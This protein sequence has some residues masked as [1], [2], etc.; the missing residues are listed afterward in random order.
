MKSQN[1][2]LLFDGDCKFCNFWVQFIQ[3]KKTKN[4]FIFLP[5]QSEKGRELLL[6]FHIDSTVDSVVYIWKDKAH[7]KSNAA[8]QIIKQFGY[9]WHTLLLFWLLPKPL[10]DWA[11][12]LIAKNRHKFFS[13]KNECD[14]H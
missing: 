6:Q 13:A 2:K 7:I 4:D 12:D 1:P 10:R 3:K 5:L 8:F 11:Y 9:L 14:L